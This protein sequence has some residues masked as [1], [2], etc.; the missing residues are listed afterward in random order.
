M[1]HS[2]Q[3]AVPNTR[4]KFKE[5]KSKVV[6]YIV[7]ATEQLNQLQ[8]AGQLTFTKA[9]NKRTIHLLTSYELVS[10]E[11]YLCDF[12]GNIY[13][14]LSQNNWI[15]NGS[16][17][18]PSLET[19]SILS[20]INILKDVLTN[21]QK[22]FYR[23][24]EIAEAAPVAPAEQTL[25]NLIPK[26]NYQFKYQYTPAYSTKRPEPQC[27]LTPEPEPEW[28]NDSDA[29]AWNFPET[30]PFPTQEILFESDLL[31]HIKPMCLK[32]PELIPVFDTDIPSPPPLRRE[33]RSDYNIK[34]TSPLSCDQTEEIEHK[35][36]RQCTEHV[37]FSDEDYKE[38]SDG[39]D[40]HFAK[41]L[42]DSF[43]P[44]RIPG[45]LEILYPPRP[46]PQPEP[47][48]FVVMEEE[49]PLRKKQR[50]T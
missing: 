31:E 3:I 39:L 10:I 29:P 38:I 42:G 47:E 5:L 24:L 1:V 37:E 50:T 6:R 33:T 45:Y 7:R 11:F 41:L 22:F 49:E 32:L 46:A 15:S 19:P 36:V 18:F 23:S 14:V 9:G 13:T 17:S 21:K 4:H 20:L 44:C 27:D 25:D 12:T 40:E 8:L 26:S 16:L 2:E 35:L 43:V 28:M 48:V 34:D 30:E